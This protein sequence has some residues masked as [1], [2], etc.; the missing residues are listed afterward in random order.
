[1]AQSVGLINNSVTYYYRK[2][3]ELDRASCADQA[4]EDHCAGGRAD[5]SA[6]P[7]SFAFTSRSWRSNSADSLRS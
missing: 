4:L 5:L 6:H 7:R 3:E 2:K 1:V